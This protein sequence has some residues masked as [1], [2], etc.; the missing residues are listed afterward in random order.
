MGRVRASG[1]ARESVLAEL[2][3]EVQVGALGS[4]TGCHHTVGTGAHQDMFLAA[5][6]LDCRA[7]SEGPEVAASGKRTY[8]ASTEQQWALAS[9]QNMTVNS[10]TKLLISGPERDTG[11][12]LE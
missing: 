10:N 1:R 5:W 7:A 11:A 6:R 4:G 3:A 12:W 2:E 9:S 8:L